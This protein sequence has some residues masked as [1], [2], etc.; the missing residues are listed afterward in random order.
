MKIFKLDENTMPQ[1]V[2]KYQEDLRS[3][4]VWAKSETTPI[5][6][7]ELPPKIKLTALIKHQ[8]KQFII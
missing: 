4:K 8:L 6:K 5:P 2:F 7:V 3:L 1:E